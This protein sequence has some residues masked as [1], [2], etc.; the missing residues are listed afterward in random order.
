MAIVSVRV[1]PVRVVSI[2]V[3]MIFVCVCQ[4]IKLVAEEMV[5]LVVRIFP[6]VAV[7]I[8]AVAVL[9]V[10]VFNAMEIVNHGEVDLVKTAQERAVVAQ[11]E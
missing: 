10:L 5:M 8:S 11:Q 7:Q 1:Q 6:S 4:K 3:T 9:T 2:V